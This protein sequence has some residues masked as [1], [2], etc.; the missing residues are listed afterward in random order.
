MQECVAGVRR[1]VNLLW[2]GATTALF[3]SQAAGLAMP[4]SDI[5]IVVMGLAQPAA[6]GLGLIRCGPSLCWA[7]L[8]SLA[9]AQRD[10]LAGPLMGLFLTAAC[11]PAVTR[12]TFAWRCCG[13]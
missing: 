10:V 13:F 5:D 4:G 8:T 7:T 12:R 6:V 2:S 9:A 3:G 1:C 11:V